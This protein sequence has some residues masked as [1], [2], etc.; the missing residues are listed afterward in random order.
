LGVGN[1]TTADQVKQGWLITKGL[2]KRFPIFQSCWRS[3]DLVLKVWQGLGYYQR[4]HNMLDTAKYIVEEN[5]AVFRIHTRV[6]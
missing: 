5:E 2:S 6:W 4:A 1:N 3:S